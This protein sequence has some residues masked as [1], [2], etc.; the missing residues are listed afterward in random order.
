MRET[1]LRE[2]DKLCFTEDVRV[3]QERDRALSEL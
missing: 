2:T 3:L 1:N